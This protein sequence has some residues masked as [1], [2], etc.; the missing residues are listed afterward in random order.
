MRGAGHCAS[1]RTD[2]VHFSG[3]GKSRWDI[4]LSRVENGVVWRFYHDMKVLPFIY[5][6]SVSEAPQKEQRGTAAFPL[7]VRT[8]LGIRVLQVTGN[9]MGTQN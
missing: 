9:T 7:R 3:T 5:E 6:L 1:Q 8:L 4:L 2:H